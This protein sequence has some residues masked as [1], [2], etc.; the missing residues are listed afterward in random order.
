[1]PANLPP[2]YFSAE[3]KYREAKTPQEKISALEE[4]LTIMPKHKG[5]DK[6][7]ASLR[8]KLAQF[9]N[10]LEAR[11]KTKKG[12]SYVIE[13]QGAGQVVMVGL[14]NSGKS[15]LVKGLTKATP[16]VADYPYTT[17]IPVPGMMDYEDVQI[18]LID[19]PPLSE[20]YMQPWL[21]DI[22]KRADL[23]L[24]MLDL[25]HDPLNQWQR[26]LTLLGRFK[27]TVVKE[28]IQSGFFIKKAVV[29]AN[30][31]DVTGAR[32]TFEIFKSFW[33][34]NLPLIPVSVREENFNLLSKTLFE[35]LE[36]IRVYSKAPGKKPDLTQPFILKKGSTVYEFADRVH[37][38]IASNLKFARIW[39][40][41]LKGLRVE[42][43]YVLKDKDIVELRT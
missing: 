26:V 41:Q 32:E 14:P 21:G 1:M 8:R 10:A 6:L 43:E 29:I 2:Q 31:L 7:R 35:K 24:I 38:D 11:R 22:L 27:I 39:N 30:K 5:T 20:D 3:K 42:R 18:Q 16:E 37:H 34:E 9:K 19:L 33:E 15:L 40:T 12:L 28:K 36:V 25:T 17:R 13:K 23:L 4:M